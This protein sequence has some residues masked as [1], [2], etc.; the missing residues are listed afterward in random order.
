MN[1]T[2]LTKKQSA[3]TALV[4]AMVAIIVGLRTG[5]HFW[6]FIAL[7]FLLVTLL[8]PLFFKPLAYIWF[9]LSKALGW[10]MSRIIVSLLF[11]ILVTPVGIVRRMMGKDTLQLKAFKKNKK[12]AFIGRNYT[13]TASDLTYPF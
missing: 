9:G 8:W 5:Q 12:T 2:I 10:L 6:F 11:Y 1:Q 13:F 7:G 4:F 3:E